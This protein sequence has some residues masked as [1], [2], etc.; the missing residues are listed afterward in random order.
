MSS[1]QKI[2]KIYNILRTKVIT[3]IGCGGLGTA[4]IYSLL[5]SQLGTLIC[6]DGDTVSKTNLHRQ[7]LYSPSDI[8]RY[9]VDCIKEKVKW[10]GFQTECITYPSFFSLSDDSELMSQLVRSDLIIDCTDNGT[11]RSE[12]AIWCKKNNKTYIFGS[13]LGFDG[14]LICITPDTGCLMCAFPNIR[15]IGDTCVDNGILA[16]VV[17]TIGHLQAMV[18]INY[19]CGIGDL[20]PNEILHYSSID[21]TFTYFTYSEEEC[22]CGSQKVV[23]SEVEMDY[24]SIGSQ[25]GKE[26]LCYILSPNGEI[27][28]DEIAY[29][30]EYRYE[31]SLVTIQTHLDASPNNLCVLVCPYGIKSKEEVISIRKQ[32]DTTRI[33]SVKYG[34]QGIH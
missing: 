11:S 14:Q 3:V 25:I 20:H 5:G 6:I 19:C 30:K 34:I 16:S 33:Y 26:V 15:E 29:S 8:G 4:C 21:G 22:K 12:I 32:L 18:A 27:D 23:C 10:G 1:K 28:M 24:D 31:H 9:K 7:F 2:N 17:N 13:A